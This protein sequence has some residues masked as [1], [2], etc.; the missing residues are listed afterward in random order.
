MLGRKLPSVGLHDFRR[1]P[2]PP[3]RGEQVIVL[4]PV[5]RML[6]VCLPRLMPFSGAVTA[7]PGV[8]APAAGA[9]RGASGP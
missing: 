3:L 4:C 2:R 9:W 8:R 5:T 6:V 1:G 7:L